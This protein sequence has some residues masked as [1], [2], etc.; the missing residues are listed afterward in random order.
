MLSPPAGLDIRWY[1]RA[2][3]VVSVPVTLL[4][5]FF[6]NVEELVHG[7][8]CCFSFSP[9]GLTESQSIAVDFHNNTVRFIHL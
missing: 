3:A 9:R 5:V 8:M 6:L 1:A 7:S 4:N 2:P